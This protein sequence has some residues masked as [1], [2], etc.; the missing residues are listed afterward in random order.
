MNMRIFSLVAWGMA[1]LV[2]VSGAFAQP[3]SLW[4]HTFGGSDRDECTSV[5]QTTDGGYILGGE[6]YSYGVGGSDF[7]LV[8]ADA[9]GDSLWSR[10]FGGSDDDVC[11]SVQQT[12]DGGYIL[13]G[14]TR[15][16]GAGS[17]HFWLVKTDVSGTEEWSRTFGGSNSDVCLSVQQTTDGG[18]ILGGYARSYGAGECD[19]WLVKTDVSGT[20]EWSRTFGGSS[21]DICW[22][23][24]QT[25]DGGYI[26][27]GYTD[28]Y[29]AGYFDFWLVKTDVSGTEEWSRTFG[30]SYDDV[31]TS[32][33]QTT[34]GGYILGGGTMSYGAGSNDFW[35]VKTDVSGT[36]LWD[37]TF[38]GSDEDVCSSV[39]QTLGG[40]YILGGYTMSYG[41]GD[42]D[43]WLVKTDASGTEE[44][45]CTFGG[46]DLDGCNSVQQTSDGGYILG[47]ET[48]SY[49]AGDSDFWLVK[50]G[51]ELAADP[52]LSPL[53]DKYVLH[54]NY[55]NPFNPSTQISFD[56]TKAGHVSLKVFDLLGREVATLMDNIQS[57]GSHAVIFDGSGLAS[58]IYLCRLQAGN[59]MTTKK[60]MLLK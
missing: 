12:T 53:P 15:S 23:V 10:T 43:F 24:Q 51:P 54:Q 6:T 13:G 46:S 57:V 1:L 5:Q 21:N 4:S 49:G 42:A 17:L 45:S 29:G 39:Q 50:T 34:D 31:C 11:F 36:Q 22:S 56:L 40:G 41:A 38:G 44:W 52:M 9:N 7:W 60:M 55:P 3:D 32:I 30:G 16:Y 59:F 20:E 14:M 33:Q 18:Y 37:T 27:A 47:G 19:F 35:L 48:R 8:R 28:S 25:T 26:L 2:L 58:G